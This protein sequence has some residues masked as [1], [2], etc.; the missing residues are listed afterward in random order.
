MERNTPPVRRDPGDAAIDPSE[1]ATDEDSA[2]FY[3]EFNRLRETKSDAIE[4][5][6]EVLAEVRVTD[7]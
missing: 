7:R 1:I 2:T 6:R 3:I 5:M 4:R